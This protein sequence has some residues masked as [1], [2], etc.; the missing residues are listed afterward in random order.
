MLGAP[1]RYSWLVRTLGIRE[2][3]SG[4]GL[5]IEPQQRRWAWT[6]V[7]GDAMDLALLAVTFGIPRVNRA[8]QGAITAAVAGMTLV[9][10]YAATKRNAPSLSGAVTPSLGME[11]G[12]H[13]PLESWRGSG[14]AEDVGANV[15]PG[16]EGE[17]DEVKQRMMRE[18][19][20]ELGLPQR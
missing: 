6:R 17:S 7:A 4:V 15:R 2:L 9:D 1:R 10:L 5:L 14:L 3:A 19:E 13:A 18:A 8:W 20:R 16:E 11:T 12:S